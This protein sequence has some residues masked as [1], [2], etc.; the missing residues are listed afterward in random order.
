MGFLL[1]S[2]NFLFRS[3]GI[4]EIGAKYD[5]SYDRDPNGWIDLLEDPSLSNWVRMP[6]QRAGALADESPWTFCKAGTLMA[7]DNAPFELLRTGRS[8]SNFI[9]HA[10]WRVTQQ[11]AD[12][13]QSPGVFVRMS[14]DGEIWHAAMIGADDA[15]YL[16]GNSRLG[17]RIHP[18]DLRFQME[19]N[20]FVRPAH[21]WN[22]YEIHC[23]D[24]Q[25]RT[26][27]N[28]GWT[29]TLHKCEVADGYVGIA[30]VAPGIEFRQLKV[31]EL[32]ILPTKDLK[33]A[34]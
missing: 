26:W 31:K 24:K 6:A 34:K 20:V 1:K 19:G 22:H 8:F 18:V 32:S 15:G 7:R 10:E 28:H 17:G 2:V 14:A 9:F 16:K 27:V 23:Q 5:S 3:I 25:I 33:P 21:A 29:S 13:F 12:G 4:S 11:F 30:S